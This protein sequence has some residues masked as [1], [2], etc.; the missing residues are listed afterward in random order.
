RRIAAANAVVTSSEWEDVYAIFLQVQKRRQE[1]AWREVE[2]QKSLTLNPEY[3]VIPDAATER[4]IR[5]PAWRATAQSRQRWQ[6][7]LRSRLDEQQGTGA[8]LRAAISATEEAT[9]PILRD[10]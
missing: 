1:P 4:T 9:L 8:A 5:L 6:D 3:F 2:R 7:T 10:T